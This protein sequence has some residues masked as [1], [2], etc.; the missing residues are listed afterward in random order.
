MPTHPC[1]RFP[2]DLFSTEKVFTHSP[3]FLP[4]HL[5]FHLP[6][7][8]KKSFSLLVATQIT[9]LH[10]LSMAILLWSPH[11]IIPYLN[12]YHRSLAELPRGPGFCPWSLYTQL[13]S[14]FLKHRFDHVRPLFKNHP[15]LSDAHRR[16]PNPSAGHYEP[17]LPWAQAHLWSITSQPSRVNPVIWTTHY[18]RSL[19]DDAC[20]SVFPILQE[21]VQVSTCC[22]R[23]S[24]IS[25]PS[26]SCFVL[27][28]HGK[29]LSLHFCPH[30]HLTKCWV[31]ELLV[32]L[33]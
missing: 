15:Q 11:L 30:H 32:S 2:M 10:L 17:L 20:Y 13:W 27:C 1:M 18:T 24:L 12:C 23:A 5:L 16:Y 19:L 4:S 3:P 26:Y 21:L 8:S 29:T 7:I 14:F 6:L 28:Y 25:F 31:T 9:S 22:G 33:T